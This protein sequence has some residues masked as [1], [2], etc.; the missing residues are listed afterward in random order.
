MTFREKKVSSFWQADKPTGQASRQVRG[1]LKLKYP[2]WPCPDFPLCEDSPCPISKV[3]AQDPYYDVFSHQGA[4]QSLRYTIPWRIILKTV[5]VCV[6]LSNCGPRIS[7][8][9]ARRRNDESVGRQH[10]H[11]YPPPAVENN[12]AGRNSWKIVKLSPM[13]AIRNVQYRL[14][15]DKVC[16]YHAQKKKYPA[17]SMYSYPLWL[18]IPQCSPVLEMN[19]KDTYCT[20]Q[21]NCKSRYHKLHRFISLLKLNIIDNVQYLVLICMYCTIHSGNHHSITP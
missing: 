15:G 8:A 10:R 18:T 20:V 6:S 3:L 14:Q 2:L 19:L 13:Y 16:M 4:Y 9:A 17:K 21:Y 11:H 5:S 12:E 7:L 1:M